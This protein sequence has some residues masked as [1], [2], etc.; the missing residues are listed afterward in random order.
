MDS[1]N[2]SINSKIQLEV[3]VSNIP[4]TVQNVK[5]SHPPPAKP[6]GYIPIPAE[7]MDLP[8][9]IFISTL[10][11][12]DTTVQ[13][14]LGI[15]PEIPPKPLFEVYP[16]ISGVTCKG[17]VSL[18]LLVNE[19]G[20]TESIEVLQNSTAQDTCLKVAIEAARKSRWIPAR[21]LDEPVSSWITKT[22]K[23]NIEK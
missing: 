2:P 5:S 7:T 8:E 11:G 19:N 6:S 12:N 1:T 4:Q 16:R 23:F 18:L 9:E 22:Y 15:A 20:R 3:Y 17:Q 13:L 10:P 14:S 21:V